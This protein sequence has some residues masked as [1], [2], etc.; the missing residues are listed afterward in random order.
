MGLA[1]ALAEIVAA[2]EVRVDFERMAA[3]GVCLHKTL[4]ILYEILKD[5]KPFDPQ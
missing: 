2:R 3:V 4:R 5:R 1:A